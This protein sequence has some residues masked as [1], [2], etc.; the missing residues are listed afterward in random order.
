MKVRV[1]VGAVYAFCACV[2]GCA[3]QRTSQEASAALAPI[4]ATVSADNAKRAIT[5]GKS[6]KAD[7]IAALGKTQVI[8][9]DSGFEVWVY[10]YEGDT[11]AKAGWVERIQ[12]AGSGTRTPDS[13]EFV[14]LF[15]PSGFVA[16]TRIR[17]APLPS[18]A[19][20]T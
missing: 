4:R 16:K 3:L 19:K 5:I 20:G 14:V 7:V 9:F 2:A 18:G 17:L 15:A 6:S 8:G 13:A 11:P 12:R 1:R 10:R